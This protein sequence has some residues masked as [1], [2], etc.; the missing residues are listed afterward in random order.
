MEC[1][2]LYE[3]WGDEALRQW[4][5]NSAVDIARGNQV[6]CIALYTHAWFKFSWCNEGNDPDFLMDEAVKIMRNYADDAGW[7]PLD[8][9]WACQ[10]FEPR[11]MEKRKRRF[12][13]KHVRQ[14][15]Q[16]ML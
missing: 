9:R 8:R 16:K 2:E 4:I 12:I 10:W 14:G 5:W 3:A 7:L 1:R 13:L 11:R 6:R 15:A